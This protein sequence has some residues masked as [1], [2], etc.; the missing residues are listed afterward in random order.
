MRALTQGFIFFGLINVGGDP[1]VIEYNCR[2][3]DPETEVVMPRLENDVVELIIMMHEN[4]LN[5]VEVK[6]DKRAA[7]TVMLVSEGYPNSYPK[8]RIMTGLDSTKGS[9][10]FHAGTANKDQQ[11]VTNGG[12][13]IAITSYGDTLKD[14]LAVSFENAK[15]IEYE[16][17]YYRRDIGYEF[18]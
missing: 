1:Y 14:A 8:G 9:I 2:M 15:H 4:R 12:R 7:C 18:S 17:K 10:L 16:G 11:V 3:G 5:E 6:H 13:V